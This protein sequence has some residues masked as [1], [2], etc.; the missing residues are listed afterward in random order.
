MCEEKIHLFDKWRDFGFQ[1]PRADVRVSGENDLLC[2]GWI[3]PDGV[4]PTRP[5]WERRTERS[6]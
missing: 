6:G 3:V 1:V 4:S 5:S 2:E